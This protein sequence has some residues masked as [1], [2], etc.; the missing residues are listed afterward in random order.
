MAGIHDGSSPLA[1]IEDTILHFLY[2][3]ENKS[4][5]DVIDELDENNIPQNYLYYFEKN[6]FIELDHGS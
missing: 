5:A 4:K 6:N 1:G 3:L 2:K